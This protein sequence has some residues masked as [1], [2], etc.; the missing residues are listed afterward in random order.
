[1]AQKITCENSEEKIK[2]LEEALKR[3]KQAE[4]SLRVSEHQFRQ[5]Y[6]HT[7]VGIAQVSLGFVI[8]R[9]NPAYCRMLGYTEEELRGKHLKDITHPEVI[10]ENLRKQ[11][12]LGR[13]E[14]DHYV[15]EKK[16]IHKQGHT[17]YG[18]LVSNLIRDAKGKPLYF[19]GSVLDI[20]DR[21]R[22]E[23]AL[24]ENEEKY[25]SLFDNSKDAILLT[26][27]D[28]TILD[29][30]PAACKI[31]GRSLEEIRRIGRDGLVD[32]TDPRLHAAVKQRELKGE[33]TAEITMLRA[34]GEKFSA[35][36]SSK[37]YLDAKGRRKT[38]MIIRD[39]TERRKMEE[40]YRTLFR[41]MLDGFAVHEIICDAQGQPVDYRFLV[42]NPAFERMTG[43]KAENIVGRTVLEVL[44]ETERLWIETYG[45]VALTGEPAF[46]ESY[47]Q[48][49]DKYFEVSAFRSA[50][51]RFVTVFADITGRKKAEKKLEESETLYRKLFEDHTAV[52]L[53]INPDTGDIID[54]NEAAGTFY[55]WSRDQLRQMKIQDINTLPPDEIKKEM[56][57]ARTR[58][59]VYFEF[60]HRRAD[61]SIRDVEVFSSK[62]VV[63]GKDVL[64]SI[65]HDITERRQAEMALRERD[66]LFKKLSFHVPGMIYQFM[67]KPDG[68]YCFPFV[69][70]AIKNVFGCSP[71]E[72][73]DEFSPIAKTI[74]PDDLNKVI[75][76]IECSA[77]QM[78]KWEC[79][80]R[81]Q[82]P[83]QPVRWMLGQSTP[84][85]LAGGSII[86]HGFN[87]DIT[88]K[89][90]AEDALR[91]S[92]EKYRFLTEAMTDIV[93]MAN[94]DDLRTTY[95]SPSI[96]N[97][98]GFTPEERKRQSVEEQLTPD[99]LS[100]ALNALAEELAREKQGDANP[101]RTIERELEFYHKDGSTRWMDVVISGIRNEQG[102]L[103]GIHGVAR[104][105]TERKHAEENLRRTLESLR[106]A[107]GATIQVMVSA[108]EARDP[109]TAG[110][111]VRSADLAGAIATE[112]ELPPEKID[113]IRMAGAIHDI[114][115]LSVPAEIL[116]KPTRLTDLEHSLVKEHAK[117]GYEMLKNVESMWP[118]AQIVYQHHERMDGSGY[119]QGLKGEDIILEAR[120]M[121][122]ADVVESMASHRPYR[123]SLGLEEALREIEKNKKILYDE[124]VVNACLRLFRE[125]GYRLPE[126]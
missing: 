4:E 121:A 8:E 105:V 16:F 55:G 89:K 57:K 79:E 1:M 71:E 117:R 50:P 77:E 83:G 61:G 40:E 118:L 65:V 91:A 6:K 22:A 73:R 80:Y 10:E 31:F 37:I 32:I 116:T 94:I 86:W 114:G 93:W 14:I 41:T 74:F 90:M 43:L 46:F 56:E 3:G 2:L 68:T 124:A 52:K 7:Q 48:S 36:I 103:T 11:A 95:V 84:E 38:S 87:A 92:E 63:Q 81:V 27:P 23:D 82:L 67:R 126:V 85:K 125:K 111:Q 59:K 104:D 99:S 96:E 18:I 98:L 76:S 70:D 112:M 88:D 24:L 12:Q 72:V 28:G 51:N 60:R 33:E 69:T 78:I 17:L 108:V 34:N 109:Y 64:H 30:N 107:V 9:A 62:I 5:I 13:G 25:R 119:P 75:N 58:K 20:T 35:E 123:A 44:P 101:A 53:M 115:K 45:R 66:I 100:W 39:M 21:K 97:L 29:A 42:V 49:L 102:V 113:G 26:T 122:V 15:M 54:A 47:A 106:K 120:I 110:H 19:L